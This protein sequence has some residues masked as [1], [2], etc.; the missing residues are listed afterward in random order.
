M[1]KSRNQKGKILVLEHLLMKTSESQIVTMQEILDKLIEYGITAERKSIYDDIEAL[2]EF[3]LDV[4][5]KR[6]RPGG[7]YLVNASVE[8]ESLT[9]VCVEEKVSE[10]CED[11]Q[12]VSNEEKKNVPAVINVKNVLCKDEIQDTEKTIKLQCS[13]VRQKEIRDYFGSYGEYKLKESGSL[14]VTIPMVAGPKFYG[15][16]TTMGKDVHILKPKKAAVS[17]RDYLKGIAKEYK[18]I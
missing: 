4:Q 3:G 17:Y 10:K 8:A 6:G 7:Y 12:N 14:Q 5:Y 9:T 13:G 1:A 18:G 2:R 15:W 11:T 16:L